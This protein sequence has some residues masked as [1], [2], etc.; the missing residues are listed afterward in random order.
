LGAGSGVVELIASLLAFRAGQLPRVLNYKSPDPA[1]P[2]AV[3]T[4]DGT[5]PGDSF[6]K[7]A[8]TPQGQASVLCVGRCE[9]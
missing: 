5:S 2:L 7:L 9:S 6:V 1:C 3:V 8:V 4:D